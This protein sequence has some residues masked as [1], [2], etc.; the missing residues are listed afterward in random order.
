MQ[1]YCAC[2]KKVAGKNDLCDECYSIYG[3]N[4]SE[5]P[6]WLRFWVSDTKRE[7]AQETRIDEHEAAFTDLGIDQIN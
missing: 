7:Y 1:R 2:G 5:W 6:G 3:R 4:S